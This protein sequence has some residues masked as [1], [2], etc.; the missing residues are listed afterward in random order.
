MGA[1]AV[2]STQQLI[3]KTVAL[4]DAACLSTYPKFSKGKA[5]LPNKS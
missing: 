3:G 4:W 2:E 5:R 1:V